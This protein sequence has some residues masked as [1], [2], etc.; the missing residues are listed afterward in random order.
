MIN[1]ITDFMKTINKN[2]Q[3]LYINRLMQLTSKQHVLKNKEQCKSKN[4]TQ[5]I[6]T[7]CSNIYTHLM[8]LQW[9]KK[10]FGIIYSFHSDSIIQ[11][12]FYIE[13]LWFIYLF[14]VCYDLVSLLMSIAIF[15]CSEN[16]FAYFSINNKYYWRNKVIR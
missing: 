11:M 5:L 2:K 12:I 14:D 1:R 6:F 9:Q 3:T 8:L 4:I 13:L 10:L 15:Y 7:D 16:C